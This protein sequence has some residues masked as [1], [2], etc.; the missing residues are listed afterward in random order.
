MLGSLFDIVRNMLIAFLIYQKS[1]A[2]YEVWLS[3]FLLSLWMFVKSCF[4][5][6]Y[7]GQPR[8]KLSLFISLRQS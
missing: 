2:A 3:M 8:V 4:R 6:F 1:L 7:S 5:C